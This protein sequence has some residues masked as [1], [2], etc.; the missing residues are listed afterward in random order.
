M[1]NSPANSVDPLHGWPEF[2]A[3]GDCTKLEAEM[4]LASVTPFVSVPNQWTNAMELRVVHGA[5]QCPPP[6]NPFNDNAMFRRV[7]TERI[8]AWRCHVYDR[9]TV[10]PRVVDK[11]KTWRPA[12]IYQS[13]PHST[14][15]LSTT[16]Y[17]HSTHIL[18]TFYP[19][20]STHILPTFYPHSTHIRPVT[21]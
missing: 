18:P 3:K 6:K 1:P 7:A 5:L 15:I 16:F 19:P 9:Q 21:F 14:H 4:H 2:R 10:R 17:S 11:T 8:A 13:G 20:H 12:A